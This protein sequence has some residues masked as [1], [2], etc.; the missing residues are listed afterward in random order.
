MWPC[1]HNGPLQRCQ[2]RKVFI[3]RNKNSEDV[4]ISLICTFLDL[5]NAESSVREGMVSI[6]HINHLP[7]FLKKFSLILCLNVLMLLE[8]D[9]DF[10]TALD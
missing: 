9:L 3:R 4:S 8:F 2:K 10:I 1:F 7:M 6:A 5:Q